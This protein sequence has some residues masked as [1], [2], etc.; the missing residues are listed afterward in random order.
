M[1]C[2]KNV[3]FE[4]TTLNQTITAIWTH[5]GFFFGWFVCLFVT[6]E[7]RSLPMYVD[8]YVFCCYQNTSNFMVW[9]GDDPNKHDPNDLDPNS[10]SKSA[11]KI[12]LQW[13]KSKW[14][15]FSFSMFGSIEPSNTFQVCGRYVHSTEFWLKSPRETHFSNIFQAD[16]C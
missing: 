7:V 5:L 10:G 15:Y 9:L 13:F 2:E 11:F 8:L 4:L 14:M 6:S 16:D 12:D 1:I 3:R